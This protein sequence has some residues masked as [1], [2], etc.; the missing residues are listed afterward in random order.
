MITGSQS[1]ITKSPKINYQN[2]LCLI[3]GNSVKAIIPPTETKYEVLGLLLGGYDLTEMQKLVAE[4]YPDLYWIVYCESS[5][6]PDKCSYAGCQAGMGLVQLIPSTAKY[7]ESKLN[8]TIN[9]FNV[10]DNLECGNWLLQNEGLRHWK[11]SQS[12]WIK[13]YSF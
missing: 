2:E 7:C 13:H 10:E 3:D 8:K 11:Q 12:C 4:K 6:R 9:P 1:L 5:F